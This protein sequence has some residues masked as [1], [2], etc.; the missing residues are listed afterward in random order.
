MITV[1]GRMSTNVSALRPDT[2]LVEAAQQMRI[3]GVGGIPA[4]ITTASA[5]GSLLSV[6]SSAR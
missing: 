1:G 5:R 3:R 4:S 2:T 6:T